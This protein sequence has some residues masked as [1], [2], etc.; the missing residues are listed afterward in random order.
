M[1]NL[2]LKIPPAVVFLICIGLIWEVNRWTFIEGL[3]FKTGTG[4]IILILVIGCLVGVLGII[5]FRRKSTSANP[6]KPENASTLVTSGIY[7]FSRNPM[8]T[9]LLIVLC[10]AAFKWGSLAGFLILPLFISYMTQFQIKPEE[11]VL[12]QKFGEDFVEYKTHVR[13]WA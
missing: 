4:I 11:T 3:S 6:H 2:E 13:R 9:A 12:E 10:A 7:T 1:K 8:Y 5:E